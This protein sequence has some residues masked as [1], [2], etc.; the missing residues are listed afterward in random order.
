MLTVH[1]RSPPHSKTELPRDRT[2]LLNVHSPEAEAALVCD[3]PH[4]Q[5]LPP[6]ALFLRWRRDSPF[7]QVLFEFPDEF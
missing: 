1:T 7:G 2:I 5:K 6:Y 3:R 4:R